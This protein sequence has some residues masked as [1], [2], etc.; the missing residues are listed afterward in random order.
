MGPVP[1]LGEHNEAVH[2]EFLTTSAATRK[3]TPERDEDTA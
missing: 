2:A 1:A 3:V